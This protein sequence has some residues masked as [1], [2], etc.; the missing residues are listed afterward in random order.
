MKNLAHNASFHSSEKTAPWKSGTKDLRF[1]SASAVTYASTHPRSS[2]QIISA[3]IVV[4]VG[5][6]ANIIKDGKL[7]REPRRKRDRNCPCFGLDL[8][9]RRWRRKGALE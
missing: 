3:E 5:G 7:T 2:K 1:V 8:M 4:P 9:R 6:A